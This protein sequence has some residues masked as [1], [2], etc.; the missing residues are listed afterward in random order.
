MNQTSSVLR[1][2]RE[3]NVRVLAE[4]G[5]LP[6]H[7][8]PHSITPPE[9]PHRFAGRALRDVPTTPIARFIADST[10]FGDL[11]EA[12]RLLEQDGIPCCIRWARDEKGIPIGV[13]LLRIEDSFHERPDISDAFHDVTDENEAY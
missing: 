13:E 4:H 7:A 2:A 5:A 8:L 1:E 9:Q 3:R 12:A 11:V 6:P 10:T